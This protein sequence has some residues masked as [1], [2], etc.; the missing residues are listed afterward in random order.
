[1]E[2]EFPS[3]KKDQEKRENTYKRIFEE[4][5]FKTDVYLQS[6]LN[7]NS[8]GQNITQENLTVQDTN[9]QNMNMRGMNR[10]TKESQMTTE[11]LIEEYKR[12]KG[13]R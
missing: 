1:M 4:G 10:P 9:N 6:F 13:L 8:Q 3:Y 11:E 12:L 2:R 5:G 7:N